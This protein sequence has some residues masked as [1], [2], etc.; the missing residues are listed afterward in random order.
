MVVSGAL[1]ST[2]AEAATLAVT[3]LADSGPGSLR[4]AL[5][6]ANFGD[7]ITF[8]VGGTITNLAGELLV[9]KDLTVAAPGPNQLA[10]SGNNACR[11]FNIAGG[12]TVTISGLTLTNGHAADGPASTNYANPGGPGADGGGIYNS[13]SLTLSNCVV[14]RCRSGQG[15]TGYTDNPPPLPQLGMGQATAETG[16][17][18]AASTTAAPSL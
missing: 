5:A 9:D 10:L 17:T 18:G 11:G 15:G 4:A 2:R 1:L 14:T 3:T 12:V 8:A 13:G 16:V 7:T 6:S